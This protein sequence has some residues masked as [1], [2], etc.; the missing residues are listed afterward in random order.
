MVYTPFNWPI[1]SETICV[2]Q[3]ERYERKCLEQWIV[4]MIKTK[5][6]LYKVTKQRRFE[7][8]DFKT[9]LAGN[10][11]AGQSPNGLKSGAKKSVSILI[12][13]QLDRC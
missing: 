7:F 3:N 5:A 9:H 10:L 12:T 8:I 2:N 6:Q 13:S 4:P 11:P 1:G